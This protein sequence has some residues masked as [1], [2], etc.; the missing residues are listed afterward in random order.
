MTCGRALGVARVQ[1]GEAAAPGR[2]RAGPAQPPAP[3]KAPPAA[4]SNQAARGEHPGRTAPAA[5]RAP[6]G[7]RVETRNPPT[8]SS[9]SLLPSAVSRRELRLPRQDAPPG[10][11]EHGRLPLVVNPLRRV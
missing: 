1:A 9:G 3:T 6:A 2:S 5:S 8:A 10:R 7:T 4:D 11:A